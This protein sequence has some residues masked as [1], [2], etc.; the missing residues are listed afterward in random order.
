MKTD[1]F[2]DQICYLLRCPLALIFLM[3]LHLMPNHSVYIDF[4][5][6]AAITQ[7]P[8]P[9]S[10]HKCQGLCIS[11]PNPITVDTERCS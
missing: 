2:Y 6:N 1:L 9:I 11:T 7:N 3:V 8:N 4:G 10:K 5:N